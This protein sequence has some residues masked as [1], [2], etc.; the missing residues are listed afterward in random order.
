VVFRQAGSRGERA[1]DEGNS[2]KALKEKEFLCTPR[3][4]D[5]A[6]RY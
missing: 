2:G 3:K 1:K 5:F 6:K 4:V